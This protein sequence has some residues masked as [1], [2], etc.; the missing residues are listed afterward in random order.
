MQHSRSVHT[1]YS[2]FLSDYSNF[3]FA[4]FIFIMI[5]VNMFSY[6]KINYWYFC[7]MFKGVNF[8]NLLRSCH[9]K[10]KIILRTSHIT[11]GAH[12]TPGAH[13]AEVRFAPLRSAPPRFAPI[14]FA[15]LHFASYVVQE[16]P[17]A[18][19]FLSKKEFFKSLCS[20]SL[21]CLSGHLAAIL[22]IRSQFRFRF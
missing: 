20:L 10:I 12:T 2:P 16:T 11:L 9:F 5:T 4:I 18:H 14:R 1:T 8:Y 22:F 7:R 3:H 6:Q 15:P 21:Y 19:T 13:N 17:A